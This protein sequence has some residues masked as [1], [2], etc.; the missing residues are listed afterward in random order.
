MNV[1]HPWGPVARSTQ[2]AVGREARTAAHD[3]KGHRLQREVDA[4]I[5]SESPE[6]ATGMPP[7]DGQESIDRITQSIWA[8]AV[9]WDALTKQ[10]NY[11]ARGIGQGNSDGLWTLISPSLIQA[12]K[13]TQLL[14]DEAYFRRGSQF[15]QIRQKFVHALGSFI[16]TEQRWLQLS[17]EQLTSYRGAMILAS[18][19]L[20]GGLCHKTAL[21]HLPEVL[22]TTKA[23]R[24]GDQIWFEFRFPEGEAARLNLPGEDEELYRWCPDDLT[25]ALIVH[26]Q[27]HH[28]LA[29][30]PVN[31]TGK[32][33]SRAPAVLQ[34]IRDLFR[35][36]QIP[37]PKGLSLG[38]WCLGAW[39]AVER[40]PAGNIPSYLAEYA[41]GRTASCSLPT[42]RWVALINQRVSPV[43]VVPPQEP[44]WKAPSLPRPMIHNGAP[45]PPDT[46]R[47]ANKLL[48]V[49]QQ[50]Y[51]A[52]LTRSECIKRFEHLLSANDLG[53]HVAAQL[54]AH[55]AIILLRKGSSW[56]QKPLAPS[57]VYSTYLAPLTRGL[58]AL[59][60]KPD[61]HDIRDYDS[62]DFELLYEDILKQARSDASSGRMHALQEFHYFLVTQYDCPPLDSPLI[63][64]KR[65]TPR[66]RAMIVT[67][68]E[69]HATRAQLRQQAKTNHSR[70]ELLEMALILGFRAGLRPAEVRKLRLHDIFVGDTDTTITVST[71]R[72]GK[73]KNRPS[74]R[75]I[76]LRALCPKVEYDWLT[77]RI[78]QLQTAAQR[79]KQA[80]LISEAPGRNIQVPDD[81]L[82]THLQPL[83]RHVTRN[84]HINFYSLRHSALTRLH[85]LA[86]IPRHYQQILDPKGEQSWPE[87]IV[88]ALTG[89][90]AES[91]KRLYA[92]SAIAGHASPETTLTTYLHGLDLILQRKVQDTLP[93][94]DA[95]VYAHLIGRN[96]ETVARYLKDHRRLDPAPANALRPWILKRL[97][98]EDHPEPDGHTSL[99]IE[100]PTPAVPPVTVVDF[101]GILEDHDHG[102]SLVQIAKRS[103]RGQAA[104]QSVID[105][106]RSLTDI[107]SNKGAARHISK[108]RR[109]KHTGSGTPLAP[110]SPSSK[111]EAVLVTTMI[112][113]LRPL[114]RD[115]TSRAHFAPAIEYYLQ[116]VEAN[117]SGVRFY[118]LDIAR[119]FVDLMEKITH[120]RRSILGTHVPSDISS[121]THTEQ[122]EYW[123]TELQ[124]AVRTDQKRKPL[125]RY[126]GELGKLTVSL[127]LY[128]V[129]D[130][131]VS[132]HA[133]KC[134]LHFA[135]IALLMS[136]HIHLD[137]KP[138]VPQST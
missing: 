45:P 118:D 11:F 50:T 1:A 60:E 120:A 41:L 138:N 8:G 112:N 99:S 31:A 137:T 42:D 63:A 9:S 71:N 43:S 55:W 121:L 59:L 35:D 20:F 88:P 44:A 47:I 116:H 114:L 21:A 28:D 65:G 81:F 29:D 126:G 83:L 73:N 128:K 24:C 111:S 68:A 12:Q 129:G 100:P 131:P 19:T 22:R 95:E 48:R 18:A 117:N 86:E 134:V 79:N 108:R 97:T 123:E 80:L 87:S 15:A 38:D 58:L 119:V 46:R 67:E 72:Y 125:A 56:R 115:P 104:C 13:R 77:D 85:L 26:F 76:D 69:Y 34:A 136:G 66:V 33:E 94:L 96:Y 84:A 135:A 23:Q 3:K 30:F 91:M 53:E 124:I 107:K 2:K 16:K 54:L 7:A 93:L 102:Y 5:L 103:G 17:E 130:R 64:A 52:R 75:R 132:T 61:E 127:T 51:P 98:T 27:R 25:A 74:R 101:P 90:D 106:A 105:A 6:L 110:S 39:A 36:L 49:C 70:S 92:V 82:R 78:C 32:S 89:G 133:Y 14:R 10:H 57:T 62:D 109:E 113:E 122:S 37:L 4:I 40:A